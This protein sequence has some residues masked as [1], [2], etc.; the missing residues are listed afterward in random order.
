MY[1]EVTPV[2][3]TI[4]LQYQRPKRLGGYSAPVSRS[5]LARQALGALPSGLSHDR[6]LL[7]TNRGLTGRLHAKGLLVLL[8]RD[9]DDLGVGALLLRE[10]VDVGYGDFGKEGQGRGKVLSGHGGW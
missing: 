1:H 6:L 8:C 9:H 4:V 10:G 5:N 2:S 7:R 3:Y